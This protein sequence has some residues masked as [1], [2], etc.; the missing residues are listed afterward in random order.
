MT[1]LPT[2][3][4]VFTDDFHIQETNRAFEG[5]EIIVDG[6][7]LTIDGEHSFEGLTITNG[8]VVTH[9]VSNKLVLDVAGKIYVS[10]DSRIDVSGRGYG[11][12]EGTS[13]RSGGSYGGRGGNRDGVSC[14]VYGSYLEP[15]DLGSG[16]AGSS[17]SRGGGIIKITATEVELMGEIRSNGRNGRSGEHQGGGSGGTVWIETGVM[18]GTGIIRANGGGVNGYGGGGGGGGRVAVYYGSGDFDMGRI[19]CAGGA[20]KEENGG[21]GTIYY[22]AETEEVGHLRFDNMGRG[23]VPNTKLNISDEQIELKSLKL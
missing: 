9:S 8:G 10:E 21:P 3:G 5:E 12:I 2:Y 7:G 18:D 15:F 17:G 14:E 22:K 1:A 13:G 11:P 6:A 20:G 4:A 16:G 19:E 23:G